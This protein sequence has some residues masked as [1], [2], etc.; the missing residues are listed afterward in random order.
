[1]QRKVS[2]A[3]DEVVYSDYRPVDGIAVPGG[4]AITTADGSGLSLTFD[5]PEINRPISADIFSP[6]LDGYEI[7]P[8]V[9]F[10]EF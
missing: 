2:A 7:L 3:G 5:E 1:V 6:Q 9:D 8:L 4:I 10:K